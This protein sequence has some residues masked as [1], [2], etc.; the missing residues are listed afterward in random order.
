[1]L[2]ET[3]AYQTP[4]RKINPT[5]KLLF[6]FTL[7]LLGVTA[8][9]PFLTLLPTLFLVSFLLLKKGKIPGKIYLKYLLL[10]GAFLLASLIGI[11][12][13]FRPN[14]Y[15]NLHNLPVALNAG[16]RALTSIL[17][18]YFLIFTTPLL[19]LI[20]GLS[21]LGVPHFLIE[22][23]IFIHR[24][25]FIFL[26]KAGEIINSQEARLGYRTFRRGI[27]SFSLLTFGIFKEGLEK[28][29]QMTISLESRGYNG[30]ITFLEQEYQNQNYP[31][32]FVGSILLL[33]LIT[34]GGAFFW[35]S[36]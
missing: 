10:P 1:M 22:I 32:V 12:I 28:A 23:I 25:I 18:L 16:G 31:K 20:A 33:G 13:D 17:G 8:P 27:Y 29:I 15:L 21:R 19:D 11:I 4:L 5:Y 36:F 24:F 34:Y 30:Q 14:P 2:T 6:S 7:L 26:E 9:N 3:L 35:K